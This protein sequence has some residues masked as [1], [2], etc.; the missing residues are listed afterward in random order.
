MGN[1]LGSS[2]I[3]MEKRD[4]RDK[5]GL[6]VFPGGGGGGGTVQ[7]ARVHK[8]SRIVE[9]LFI[10]VVVCSLQYTTNPEKPCLRLY[11]LKR[12]LRI[13]SF[14]RIFLIYPFE[15]IFGNNIP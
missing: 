7:V 5:E 8:I 6:H 4:D 3:Q 9:D 14:K 12:F 1:L 13:Y 11:E 15:R 2:P 10:I